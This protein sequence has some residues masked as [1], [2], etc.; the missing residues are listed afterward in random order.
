MGVCEVTQSNEVIFCTSDQA[1]EA[2]GPTAGTGAGAAVVHANPAP[3]AAPPSPPPAGK[4]PP[5]SASDFHLDGSLVFA[6]GSHPVNPDQTL[7]HDNDKPGVVASEA[8]NMSFRHTTGGNTVA[9]AAG[10]TGREASLVNA[11]AIGYTGSV[12]AGHMV[13]PVQVGVEGKLSG[14]N[15]LHMRQGDPTDEPAGIRSGH[16]AVTGDLKQQLPDGGS[17][18]VHAEAGYRAG[19]GLTNRVDAIA[20]ATVTEHVGPV[21]LDVTGRVLAG[22]WTDRTPEGQPRRIDVLPSGEVKA[23]LPVTDHVSVVAKVGANG[24]Y[25]NT[26]KFVSRSFAN[27][28]VGA[29]VQFSLDGSVKPKK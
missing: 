14:S 2:A 3:Q 22:E 6:G 13:G 17:V 7:S 18:A 25:S 29:G 15:L 19:P 27:V 24:R 1:T 23:S 16:I 20:Q 12:K 28:E 11:S 26:D 21:T 8:V 9:V 10:L 5:V 4:E